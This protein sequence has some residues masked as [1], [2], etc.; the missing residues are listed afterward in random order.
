M[1]AHFFHLI[2]AQTTLLPHATDALRFAGQE[3]AARAAADQRPWRAPARTRCACRSRFP[4]HCAI[5]FS[6][7]SRA[8]PLHFAPPLRARSSARR[9][10]GRGERGRLEPAWIG[11][12]EAPP[13]IFIDLSDVLC[14]AI[15]HDTCAGIPR[16]QLEIA[17]RLLSRQSR[18]LRLWPPSR[19]MVR[20]WPA[21]RSGGGRRRP[22]LRLA[23]GK[24]HGL[25]P[26]SRGLKLF[27]R[28]RRRHLPSRAARKCRTSGR[29]IICSSAAP[30]G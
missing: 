4:M 24:L 13:R 6:P 9:A 14:H 18:G 22:H 5:S 23:Q 16:V 15:W 8:V 17:G 27:V 2:D 26:R 10:A 1:L 21:V 19:Q 20:P 25:R 11:D 12:S 3:A 7:G 29:R 28:R 30:S